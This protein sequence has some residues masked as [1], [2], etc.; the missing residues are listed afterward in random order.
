MDKIAEMGELL[1]LKYKIWYVG[2]GKLNLKNLEPLRYEV[3]FRIDK[4]IVE[5]KQEEKAK[6]CV[7][8]DI[9][10]CS[11]KNDPEECLKASP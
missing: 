11:T 7:S 2:F 6:K 3:Q 8:C 9:T 1:D 4:L 10:D 5:S